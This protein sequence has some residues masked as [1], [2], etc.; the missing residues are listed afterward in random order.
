MHNVLRSLAVATHG[1]K[2][3]LLDGGLPAMLRE[4]T[5]RFGTYLDEKA[6]GKDLANA[7]IMLE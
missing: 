7:R 4:M 5:N 1:L 3:A 6:R 2:T